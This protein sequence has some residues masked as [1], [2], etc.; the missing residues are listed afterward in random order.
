MCARQTHDL[1]HACACKSM[2]KCDVWGVVFTPP[3]GCN[4][5]L[6]A[7][8]DLTA[9]NQ[10]ILQVDT[11]E[12]VW[13]IGTTG[14]PV[15]S[16]ALYMSSVA[17][18]FVNCH[19]LH[20]ESFHCHQDVLDEEDDGCHFWYCQEGISADCSSPDTWWRRCNLVN[21]SLKSKRSL[22]GPIFPNL[23]REIHQ[24]F[25]YRKYSSSVIR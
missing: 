25:L 21:A 18:F 20:Q 4:K 3:V 2:R 22:I 6:S 7:V 9:T 10:K 14:L 16:A 23:L 24:F 1:S 15:L 19:E 17:D 5:L 11:S 13:R 12:V 8:N